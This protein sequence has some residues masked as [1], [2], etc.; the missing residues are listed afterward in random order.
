M[1]DRGAFLSTDWILAT[2]TKTNARFIFNTAPNIFNPKWT[3]SSS[4][5]VRTL[6]TKLNG[7]AYYGQDE[8]WQ[9]DFEFSIQSG[10]YYKFFSSKNT[11]SNNDMSIVEI[12]YL[13]VIL[14]SVFQTPLNTNVYSTDNVVISVDVSQT[15]NTGEYLYLRYTTDSWSTSEFAVMTQTGATT[16]ESTLPPMSAGTVVKYYILTTINSSPSHNDIDFLT[17]NFLN[18]NG[19]NYEYTV[20]AV[21]TY[22]GIFERKI[23]FNEGTNYYKDF[24]DTA[25]GTYGNTALLTLKGGQLK[26]WEASPD[27]IL[28]ANMYYRIYNKDSLTLPNFDTIVL[29]W[30]ADLS[31][32]GDQ[33]WEND[34]LNAFLLNNLPDGQYNI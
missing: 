28:S 7:E 23:T 17:L 25:L 31:V 29:P 12:S 19:L 27:D 15:L 34:T 20:Q 1:I 26:T 22:S 8:Y 5:K 11:V 2:V 18:N 32:P 33:I 16:Y 13:P 14:N 9:E 6:N 24:T 4:N 3:G 30:R 10:R 21:P